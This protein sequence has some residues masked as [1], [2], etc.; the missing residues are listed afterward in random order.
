MIK[1]QIGRQVQ[2]FRTDNSLEYC[3]FE[4]D[5]FYN[6]EGIM[7][8]YTYVKT[9]QQNRVV[10]RMNKTLLEKAHCMLSH[11]SLSKVF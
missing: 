6:N 2:H 5:E 4:F 9:S 8:H 3:N 10:K 1:K 7:R 11:S